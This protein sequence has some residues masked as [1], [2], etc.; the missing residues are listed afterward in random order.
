MA[1]CSAVAPAFEGQPLEEEE[2]TEGLANGMRELFASGR[3][4]EIGWREQQLKGLIRFM[5][6]REEEILAALKEDLGRNTCE[7]IMTDICGISESAKGA[8]KNLSRWMKPRKVSSNILNAPASSYILAEPHG[9]VLIIAPWNFPLMLALD[10]LVGAVAAGNAAVLKPSELSRATSALLG[11]LLPQYL[12]PWLIRVVQGG[13]EETQTLLRQRWDK[14]FFTGSGR[15]GK[16]VMAAAAEHLTPVILELGGKNPVIVDGTPNLRVAARRICFGKYINGGQACLAPDYVLV[17]HDA[18]SKLTEELKKVV[19]ESFGVEPL[20]S[21]NLSHMISSAHFQRVRGLLT[22]RSVQGC[23]VIGGEVD[24]E[25]MKIAPTILKDVPW[26]S[27]VMSEEVFGPILCVQSV[28][29][30]REAIGIINSRPKPLS[31][32]IF[33][34]DNAAIQ[35]FVMETSSGG[36][37]IN[38][39]FMHFTNPSLP[40]GGVGESGMGAYHGQTSFESFSHLKP[41]M[42]KYM[43]TDIEA[44]FPPYS[45]FKANIIRYVLSLDIGG[46]LLFLLGLRRGK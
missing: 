32:H 17:T 37:L 35:K 7:S 27:P 16:I 19:V 24:E 21:E 5:E 38:D 30:V 43:D 2:T 25:K 45:P 13:A 26:D 6:E 33:S 22:D 11:R 20:L 29:S 46:L 14:I 23:L 34:T 3:S 28:G 39:V 1:E 4:R 10:P 12:D 42:R 15:V 40:F 44:R 8:L 36:V 41:V 31:S 18:A 9:V